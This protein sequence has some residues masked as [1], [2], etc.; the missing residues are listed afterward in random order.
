MKKTLIIGLLSISTFFSFG[1]Q[2]ESHNNQADS[3]RVF[4]SFIVE[5]D[6]SITDVKIDKLECFKCSKTFKKNIKK[7]AVRVVR[8]TPNMGE[9]KEKVKY[10][11]PIK[12]KLED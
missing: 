2:S 5:T 3:A 11:L 10:V 6:G 8:A 12:F 7:E 4:V 1:Q 9:Q